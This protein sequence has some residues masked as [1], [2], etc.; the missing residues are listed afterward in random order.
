[1]PFRFIDLDDRRVLVNLAGEHEIVDRATLTSLVEHRLG[2]ETETYQNL[3]AKHFLAD[4]AAA[5][6]LTLLATKVRT[7]YSFLAGFTRLHIFVITLRCDH[8]CHYCQVSRVSASKSKYDMTRESSDRALDLVFRAPARDLKIEF[9]GGEPLLNFDLIRYVVEEA[10]R[11]NAALA[12]QSRKEIQFVV[13]TNLSLISDEMLQF[14]DDWHILVSTS[15]DGPPFVHNTNR[16]RPGNDAYERTVQGIARVREALGHAAVSALMTTTRLSLEH[17]EAIV[18]EYI[19]QGFDHIFLRPIS[20]YGFA[21]R[22]QQ[23]TGY[24]RYS[25]LEFYRR[26]LAYIIEMNRG[27]THLVEVYAQIFLTKVLTPFATGYVDLQSPAG[28]GI[29]AVV[30]NYDGDVYVSDEARM[31]AEMGDKSFRL[32]NLHTDSY[33]QIF[34]GPL[35]RALVNASCT[36]AMPGCADCAFQAFCGADPVENYA[37]QGDVVGHR[38]TSDFCTRNMGILKQLL[39]QYHGDDPFV[40]KL[41]RAWVHHAP[42]EALLPSLP[43]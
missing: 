32:G 26:A 38:P 9:Q 1:L 16:P 30:Y 14:F 21:V 6:P 23:R 13:A 42:I 20:P 27:G 40:R 19:A 28:A 33:D 12:E 18:D 4:T 10:D 7:K 11:R 8:S 17:P 24:D 15:L 35:L 39:R 31:L 29:G 37:T 2:P 3:K 5:T 22:T 36:D 25:F 34:G 41:F 43:V